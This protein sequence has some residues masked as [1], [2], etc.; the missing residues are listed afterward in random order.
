MIGIVL[1]G[2]IIGFGGYIESSNSGNFSQQG[3]AIQAIYLCFS[4]LPSLLIL[5]SALLMIRYS[6]SEQQLLKI[7]QLKP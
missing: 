4:V 7:K 1:V 3:S 5:L 2:L 6:F